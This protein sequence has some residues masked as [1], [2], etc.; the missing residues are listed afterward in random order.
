VLAQSLAV[1]I[2]GPNER[3]RIRDSQRWYFWIQGLFVKRRRF[4]FP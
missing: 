1:A 2:D 4:A 3:V